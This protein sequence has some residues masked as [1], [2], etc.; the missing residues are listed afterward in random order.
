[1]PDQDILERALGHMVNALGIT[2]IVSG[3]VR[4]GGK[5]LKHN[6]LGGT[7]QREHHEGLDALALKAKSLRHTGLVEGMQHATAKT[8][9]NGGEHYGL[10]GN[11]LIDRSRRTM[12]RITDHDI[13]GR[14]LA[15][16]G[17]IPIL[18]RKSVV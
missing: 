16:L 4:T 15:L 11:S 13:A 5:R 2:P 10:S 14:T 8:G 18:D 9:L 3:S 7:P 1:M 17:T 12:A 6:L